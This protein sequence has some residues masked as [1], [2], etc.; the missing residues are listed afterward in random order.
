VQFKGAS[1]YALLPDVEYCQYVQA[2]R[3]SRPRHGTPQPIPVPKALYCTGPHILG[4]IPPKTWQLVKVKRKPLVVGGTRAHSY[5]ILPGRTTRSAGMT[6]QQRPLS[7]VSASA[8]R[9]A[10]C[11]QTP[12]F[13]PC[14]HCRLCSSGCRVPY[15]VNRPGPE[16]QSLS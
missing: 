1:I 4:S 11:A 10:V 6:S 16:G 14:Y 7:H 8:S 15:R 9:I 13:L 2:R 3:H 5:S 12:C